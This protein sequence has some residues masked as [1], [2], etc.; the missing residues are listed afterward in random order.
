MGS[1]IAAAWR[2][3]A[4]SWPTENTIDL[5]WKMRANYNAR[6]CEGDRKAAGAATMA[7]N[8]KSNAQSNRNSRKS[9]RVLTS[10]CERLTSSDVVACGPWRPNENARRQ[11]GR[12]TTRTNPRLGFQPSPILRANASGR[13]KRSRY[14]CDDTYFRSPRMAL[15]LHPPDRKSTRLNSS[16]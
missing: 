2:P 6:P 13:K 16:H 7:S 1:A 9:G 14:P 4:P 8:G 11:R 10:G 15:A 5:Q 12:A 3:R